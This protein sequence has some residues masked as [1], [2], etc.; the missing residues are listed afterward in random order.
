MDVMIRCPPHIA[1]AYILNA[2]SF[3]EFAMQC[4]SYHNHDVIC[5][6]ISLLWLVLE[7]P[8]FY[9]IPSSCGFISFWIAFLNIKLAVTL[10]MVVELKTLLSCR[11]WKALAASYLT[12]QGC[13]DRK[14]TVSESGL[15][16]KRKA[17]DKQAGVR[18]KRGDGWEKGHFW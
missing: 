17:R 9:L 15:K 12:M 16:E 11:Q 5:F 10:M 2:N 14:E 1:Y 13:T 7:L 18:W 8:G 4:L 6:C 3:I